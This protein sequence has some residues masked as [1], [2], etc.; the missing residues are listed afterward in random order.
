MDRGESEVHNALQIAHC[1]LLTLDCTLL[2]RSTNTSEIQ[3][4]SAIQEQVGEMTNNRLENL[5]QFRL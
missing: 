1:I 5:E 4:I 3:R 2:H